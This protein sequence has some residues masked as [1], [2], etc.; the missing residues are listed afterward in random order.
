MSELVIGEVR[1][2]FVHVFAPYAQNNGDPKYSVTML[3][4]KSNTVLVQQIQA[5]IEQAKQEGVTKKFGGT[6]PGF[7]RSPLHDGDG[8]MQSGKP[9]GEECK[10]HYV[11]AASCKPEFGAPGV[12]AGPDRHP[13]MDQSEVYSGSY[14]YV[15]VNFGAYSDSGNVG[16]GC[17]LQHVWKTRDGEAFAGTR[18][19][20]E[21]AFAGVTIP[22]Q[23]QPAAQPGYTQPAAVQPPYGQAPQYQQPSAPTVTPGYPQQPAPVQ[24][25]YGQAPAQPAVPQP[26]DPITGQPIPPA[27]MGI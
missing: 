19:S 17:Y 25:Q 18:T 11:M 16:V 14:G 12:V 7:V 13:A 22:V 5:A 1:L 24:P 2:S 23:G 26:V 21:D 4:P 3:I 10:G 20:V 9:Y 8:V 6:M 15:A 27:V